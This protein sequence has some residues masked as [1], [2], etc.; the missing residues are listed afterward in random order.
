MTVLI[1]GSYYTVLSYNRVI[2]DSYLEFR[3]C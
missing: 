2:L 1:N 3:L